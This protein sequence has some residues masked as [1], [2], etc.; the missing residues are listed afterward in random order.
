ME[1]CVEIA[2]SRDPH[3]LG[4]IS[5]LNQLASRVDSGDAILR[6]LYRLGYHVGAGKPDTYQEFPRNISTLSS[7]QLGDANGYWQSELSRAIEIAGVID[8]T[9]IQARVKVK[10]A[11]AAAADQIV[12]TLPADAKRPTKA[13]LDRQVDLDPAVMTAEDELALLDSVAA[14][15][16]AIRESLDGRCRVLSREITRRGDTLRFAGHG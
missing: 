6:M 16:D 10:R 7:D 8:A 9:R 4:G 11:R 12:Q 3:N 15:F 2:S 5:N 1:R 14:T 13:D